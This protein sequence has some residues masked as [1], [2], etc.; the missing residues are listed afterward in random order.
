MTTW[1]M[2]EQIHREAGT[3]VSDHERKKFC[4]RAKYRLEAMM[5]GGYVIKDRKT[6]KYAL[7]NTIIGNGTLLLETENNEVEKIPIG[8]TIIVEN[9]GMI[10]V[11]LMEEII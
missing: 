6:R 9:D 1:E 8:K 10:E 3:I 7:E 11:I 2:A 4:D 5:D